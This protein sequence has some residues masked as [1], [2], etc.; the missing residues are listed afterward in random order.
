MKIEINKESKTKQQ[1]VGY[2]FVNIGQTIHFDIY[3][4]K[5]N[6]EVKHWS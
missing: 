1:H 4:G 3:N 6:V 5:K 2:C